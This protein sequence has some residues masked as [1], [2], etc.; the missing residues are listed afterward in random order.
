MVF[1]F[2]SSYTP[3]DV[4]VSGVSLELV[5]EFNYLGSYIANNQYDFSIR[6]AMAWSSCKRM[7][8]IWQSKLDDKTK[9]LI[10][11]STIENIMFYGSET[12]TLP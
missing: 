7:C 3:A 5:K 12:W 4:T 10:F 2:P 9:F 8:N 6:K 11:R 1:N